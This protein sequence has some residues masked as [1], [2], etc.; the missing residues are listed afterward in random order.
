MAKNAIQGRN[1]L[2]KTCSATIVNTQAITMIKM[3]KQKDSDS[4][5]LDTPSRDNK[6]LWT[7]KVNIKG[8]KIP[9]N[10]TDKFVQIQ[11]HV[12]FTPRHVPL[13]PVTTFILACPWQKIVADL[14]HLGGKDY[15]VIIDYF[16]YFLEVKKLK[17]TMTQSVVNT[18]KMI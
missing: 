9:E 8:K 12:I 13:P 6:S 2:Q 1:A 5:F 3:I 10:T 17:T 16:S 11:N 18:L 15:L 7:S 14:F 4:A